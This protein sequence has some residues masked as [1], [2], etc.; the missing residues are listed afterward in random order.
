MII[1]NAALKRAQDN[2]YK[3]YDELNEKMLQDYAKMG[4]RMAEIQGKNAL[5]ARR[6]M[7]RQ[8]CVSFAEAAA[9][10]KSWFAS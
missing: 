8:A 1:A 5:D 7:A 2:Y 4:E 3:K 6:E 10:P 9:L